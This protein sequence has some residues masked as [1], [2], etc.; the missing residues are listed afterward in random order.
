MEKCISLGMSI[1][2]HYAHCF[3]NFRHI[4]TLEMFSVHILKRFS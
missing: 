2:E 3:Y 4:I 1:E